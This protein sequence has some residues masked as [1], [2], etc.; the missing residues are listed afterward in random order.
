MDELGIGGWFDEYLG[1]L[2]ARGRGES[3]DLHA[4][5][6]YYGVPLLVAT[7]DEARTLTTADDVMGFAHQQVEGMRAASY[8]HTQTIDSE[9]TTLNMTS[10]L[11]RADFARRRADG[12]DIGRLG[13]TYL[14]TNGPAGLRISALAVHTP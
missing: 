14:I 11:Y 7:D 12:T 13:V 6:E 3:D 2:A 9:I 10:G 1:A 8:D 4:L 5:L